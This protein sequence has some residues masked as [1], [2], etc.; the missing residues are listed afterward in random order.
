MDQ[1][2]CES[3]AALVVRAMCCVIAADARVR[4]SEIDVVF[5]ALAAIGHRATREQFR[6]TVIST[7]QDIYRKGV[8]AVVDG[9][10]EPLANLRG[11]PLA[12][13][14]L[15]LQEDVMNSDG[16]ASDSEKAIVARFKDV[17]SA[18]HVSASEGESTGPL[19]ADI[20]RVD[21][22][23]LRLKYTLRERFLRRFL[24]VR[25]TVDRCVGSRLLV[26]V[27]S[28]C[29]LGLVS[30]FATSDVFMALIFA[31]LGFL[32]AIGSLCFGT[33]QALIETAED[34][35]RERA[36]ERLLDDQAV[37]FIAALEL[38][39]AVEAATVATLVHDDAQLDADQEREEEKGFETAFGLVRN[40]PWSLPYR[41]KLARRI[42]G[43][44][45]GSRQSEGGRTACRCTTCGRK[46]WFR[47]G[48]NG[49]GVICPYCG[50]FQQAVLDW[51]A[52]P[53][54]CPPPAVSTPHFYLDRVAVPSLSGGPVAVRGY[55][56]RHGTWVQSHTRSRPRRRRW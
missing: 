13:L 33:D 26:A 29:G 7:C 25:R 38:P 17:L 28:G 40:Q 39:P 48:L 36:I 5:D 32:V 55:V 53:P 54:P 30:L 35:P 56:N 31:M 9:L 8:S 47:F 23:L 34:A 11:G 3:G 4:G 18:E 6:T 24:S 46:Y 2:A 10:C 27:V 16:R 15:Q 45:L 19:S 20:S 50:C 49:T 41:V 52:V 42:Y 14:V 51:R 1:E 22:Q 21:E 44:L 43:L 12:A 37:S